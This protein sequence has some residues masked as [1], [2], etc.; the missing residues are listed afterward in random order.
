LCGPPAA[1]TILLMGDTNG[2]VPA[3][4]I[5]V[6]ARELRPSDRLVTDDIDVV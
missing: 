5:T 6:E 1:Y 2:N 4:I 3:H